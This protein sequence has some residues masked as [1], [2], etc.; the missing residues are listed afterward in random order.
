MITPDRFLQTKKAKILY[1]TKNWA[2]TTTA[3]TTTAK[4]AH[5]SN[6]KGTRRR[7]YLLRAGA[8]TGGYR[9]STDAGFSAGQF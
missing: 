9:R 3:M 4:L 1:N 7:R 8:V 5:R 2:I 6:R